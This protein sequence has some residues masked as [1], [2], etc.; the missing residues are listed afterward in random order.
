MRK[1]ILMT[2]LISILISSTCFA[3]TDTNDKLNS[4]QLVLGYISLTDTPAKVRSVYGAPTSIK[5]NTYYYG[6]SFKIFF[7][8]GH[9]GIYDM[10]TT[11][12]N[13][14]A[15]AD[16]VHVGMAEN[17]LND[18]Y[19][20]PSSKRKDNSYTNYYYYGV[21]GDALKCLIFRVSN[22]K[23]KEISLHWSD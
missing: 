8:D 2:S 20:E 13:G 4:S 9:N 10:T 15:T 1:I 12:N 18:V 6:N 22:G 21:G 5:N 16:G 3:Y 7:W 14:I 11:E 19:G 17:V 23:I